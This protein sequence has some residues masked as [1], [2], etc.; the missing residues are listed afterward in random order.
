MMH[1]HCAGRIDW[2]WLH[3]LLHAQKHGPVLRLELQ[4]GPPNGLLPARYECIDRLLAQVTGRRRILL[5]P[6]SQVRNQW[7]SPAGCMLF[8]VMKQLQT[9]AL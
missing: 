9:I 2:L 1:M 8:H 5:I 7:A 6:P 4:A 3:S